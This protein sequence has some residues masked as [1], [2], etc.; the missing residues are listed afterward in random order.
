MSLTGLILKNRHAVWAL[1]VGTVILGLVAYRQIPVR[2][3]P[4]TAPPLVNVVTGWPGATAG[5]VDR[6][7]TDVIATELASLEGVAATSASSQDNLSVI[8][9]EFHYGTEVR[10]AAVD[11]QNAIARVAEDLPDG[12]EQPRVMTFSTSD[13]P[14]YTVG[15]VAEDLLEARRAAEDIVG[16]RLQRIDGVAA[17][18]VFGGR[19]PTVVV[20]VDPHLAEAHH[21]PL[22]GIAASLRATDVSAP[23]GRLRGTTSETMLRIDQR[24][25]RVTD[26]E[27]VLLPASGGGQVRLGDL[28]SV[29][30][31]AVVDD[32]WFSINGQRAIAVQVYRSE[33]ANTVE[34][35]EEV[36]DVVEELEGTL[37]GVTFLPGE[38]SASFTEQSV[39]NL[40][41]NVWQALLLASVI[42]FLFLGRAR[43]AAVT[44][45]TMPLAFGLTFGVMWLV[46][47]EF[48]MVTLSAV[49]LA[50]GMVVDASVVVLEN[51]MRLRE[52]GADPDDAAR[53][54]AD[55]V[56]L[57][58]LA[59]AA[60]TL[61]VLIPLLGLPGFVGKVFGPLASTLIIAFTSSVV[62]ALVL[63]P[64]L[65]LQVREGGRLE[66][67]AQGLARPFQR[68]MERLRSVYLALL[69]LGLRRR[70]P[71]LGVAFLSFAVGLAG[72]RMA[73][74][75]LLPRMDGGTF[76]VS[77]ET[78]SGSSLSVTSDIIRDIEEILERQPEVV[79]VQSQAGF[80]PGMK[81]T[82][83][84]GVM[85]PTQGFMSV[86]LSPRTERDRDIWAIEQEVRAEIAAIPGIA[87]VVVKEVGNTA[88][89][90]TVAPIVARVSGPDPLVLDHLGGELVRT[91]EPVPNLVKPTRAWRRDMRRTVVQVDEPRAAAV[92]QTP[93]S[94]ARQL[95]LGAEG[96]EI[97]SFTPATGSAEPI[98]VRYRPTEA[99]TVDTVLSW[100]LM[101]QGGE[102]MPVAAVARGVH[103]VEQGLITSED[104]APV[105]DVRAQV[106]GRPL[107]F[108]VSDAQA[109]VQTM[110]VP[111]GY[112]VSIQGE[113][114][115]LVESRISILSALAVSV[116]A[117]YLLLVAQ[118]R[119]WV[120][121]IT[122]MMAIPLSLSGVSAA[123]WLAGKPVSM[124]VMVGLVLL[125]GTV[126]NNSI[127]LVD[128]I[129]QSREDGAERHEALRQAVESRFRPIMMTSLSTV[130]G[131]TPLALELA[132]G[133]ERF[134]PLATAVIGG[135][136]ASTLLTMVVIPVLY[137][138]VDGLR[139]PRWRAPAA[140][141]VA[142]L[143]G[144]AG[145]VPHPAEAGDLTIE[146]A[147]HLTEE[148]PAAT[149]SEHRVAAAR[150]Q[151]AAAT[152]R[153][154]PQVELSARQTWRNP[155]EPAVLTLPITLP[156]GSSPDPITL[157]EPFD[158][159]QALGV[160]VTQPLFAGGAALRGRQ[161]SREMVEARR[162]T[163]DV[164][165][166]DLWL[167]LVRGW[168][169]LE[170]AERTVDIQADAV[171][172]A[173]ARHATLERLLQQGRAVDHELATVAL[174]V[175]EA[176]QRLAE[177][178][179]RRQ[180]AELALAVLLGAPVDRAPGDLLERARSL[181]GNEIPSGTASGVLEAQA[182]ASAA[183]A[184]SRA[185]TGALM[186]RVAA[187]L[188]AQYANPDMSQF[189]AVTEWG[190]T[191]SAS[192]VATW[193]LDGGVRWNDAR[194]ARFEA[195]AAQ[196]GAEALARQAEV[197]QAAAS[198]AIDLAPGQLSIAAERVRLAEEA[199]QTTL[200]AL[201]H[202]RATHT[203][204]LDREAELA[205]A[206]MVQLQ[207]ALD[208]IVAV[209][210]ARVLAGHHG[211]N[212][213]LT[214]RESP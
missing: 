130:I 160:T 201:D 92:G 72:L 57:P 162:A 41:G 68:V 76:T 1:V 12:A 3:F 150:A 125:V 94:I 22:A 182:L 202:G 197:D 187:R 61:V 144:V 39:S 98:L 148:H 167:G 114:E 14:V 115:D 46:G 155:F 25:D 174:R 120:H 90:T 151:V 108:V 207:V 169:G 74:M 134:S 45:F 204:V 211:P 172:A 183:T 121:P 165:R 71:V 126:V 161:A 78:P 53:D 206:R 51:I 146:E 36:R 60:T 189:P 159:Q 205:A 157:G 69:D 55:Q 131:M 110:V 198:T 105:L 79:L 147:W 194:S 179:E 13:R 87:N 145:V 91:L 209:E 166:G 67:L 2:L 99:A 127:L 52:A 103:T 185:V 80:E 175:S 70:W 31:G 136:A 133:A 38:E 48:N 139:L 6:D 213:D 44:A 177:A 23:A 141:V 15:L 97:G 123:L 143:V 106:D 64:I 81:F 112:E 135:M 101:L 83:G 26:L 107:S 109:A 188:D 7:V 164:T 190:T 8:S 10:L 119:S 208:A 184:R 154:F 116:V 18:D 16:P 95:A 196:A 75:D 96:V 102:T 65:S 49:I 195:S 66:A 54:G 199:R 142:G 181:L 63:V 82:G 104:L 100:P 4:D 20:D 56:Q 171:E 153:L 62:V 37:T 158:Q 113:N 191:W 122:V 129:R 24:V 180:S 138:V 132:L 33:D 5:D 59:G 178:E 200:T 173:Q 85:G 118:F 11:V 58:V 34:V 170:V 17:V 212:P 156:D 89:P 214:H 27:D 168:Y 163:A 193:T 88:K 77:L 35:V 124:P 19:V 111:E 32:A 203:D 9:V 73:G 140:S 137:D 128:L 117:V 192:V 93:L 86:T 152:G 47:I 43:A 149:A 210:E 28:A 42:L 176:E 50:V 21:L 84:S 40:L 186:P 30:R 29:E